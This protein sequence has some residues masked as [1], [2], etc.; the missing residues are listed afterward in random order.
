MFLE[1]FE[2]LMRERNLTKAQLIRATGITEGAID[3]WRKKGTLPTSEYLGRLADFFEV[4]VDYLLGRQS[5]IGI[6]EVQHEL[7]VDQEELLKIY[8]RLS[9]QDKSQLLALAKRFLS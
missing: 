5:D 4:S 2:S 1:R 7:T 8:N 6:V 9:S 3:G